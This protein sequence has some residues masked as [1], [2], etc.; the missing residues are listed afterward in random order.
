M[1]KSASKKKSRFKRKFLFIL[2]L[3]FVLL[4][5]LLGVEVGQRFPGS[6]FKV[7]KKDGANRYVLGK[8]KDE[9]GITEVLDNSAEE[10]LPDPKMTFYDSLKGERQGEGTTATSPNSSAE[11][12]GI[13]REIKKDTK[14]SMPA[15][16]E[17]KVNPKPT[18]Y[19]LQMGSYQSKAKAE[20]EEK[21]LRGKD[22]NTYVIEVNIPG[23][24]TWYRVKIGDYEDLE[25]AQKAA[26]DFKRKEGASVMIT[27]V[28]N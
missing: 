14:N 15:G 5:F 11:H 8:E 3:F 27:D 2:S 7:L 26:E 4:V 6:P 20:E 1:R 13:K 18:K 22:Y 23:K 25:Q 19:A 21:E 16:E 17:S 9:A 28:S 12:I 24:G 10:D